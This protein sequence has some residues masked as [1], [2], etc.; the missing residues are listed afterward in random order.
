MLTAHSGEEDVY[1]AVHAGAGAYLLKGAKRA[2]Q[3]CFPRIVIDFLLSSP[4]MRSRVHVF[5]SRRRV[6][7]YSP[8]ASMYWDL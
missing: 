5:P 1:R 3:L 6:H 4:A 8:W 2:A 7:F